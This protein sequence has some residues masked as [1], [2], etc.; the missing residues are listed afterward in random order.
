MLDCEKTILIFFPFSVPNLRA[1]WIK[2]EHDGFRGGHRQFWSRWIRLHRQL[3]L[4]ALGRH[5]GRQVGK[6][7]TAHP[8]D[9]YT[10]ILAPKKERKKHRQLFFRK[11]QHKGA[12]EKQANNNNTKLTT[13]LNYFI[14][15]TITIVLLHPYNGLFYDVWLEKWF[16]TK[17]TFKH[18]QWRDVW[19]ERRQ[20]SNCH[21][22]V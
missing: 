4:W 16:K 15:I 20:N 19:N 11:K 3:H 8:S 12:R 21:I 6:A 10:Y 17:M 13:F 1:W 22:D 18:W 7:V 2:R 14:I 5:H 9:T